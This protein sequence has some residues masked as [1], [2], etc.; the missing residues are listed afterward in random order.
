MFVQQIPKLFAIV[1]RP[2][3]SFQVVQENWFDN[4]NLW[5]KL[6]PATQYASLR[7]DIILSQTLMVNNWTRHG[8]QL[9][10]TAAGQM[11]ILGGGVPQAPPPW[12]VLPP[13]SGDPPQAAPP[14]S[15]QAPPP[16][17]QLPGASL[18]SWVPLMEKQ[19]EFKLPSDW[20]P[21]VAPIAC[22]LDLGLNFLQ[23]DR[24]SNLG[25]QVR[26]RGGQGRSGMVRVGLES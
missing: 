15:Q 14:F 17:P 12:A 18:P 7:S 6:P 1:C 25:L 3:P 10:L 5:L 23:S 20:S 26:A 13:W 8:A 21:S 4:L 22:K 2:S 19:L 24:L 11:D 16:F 9:C